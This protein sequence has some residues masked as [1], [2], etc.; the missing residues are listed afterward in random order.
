MPDSGLRLYV[1]AARTY[2][3]NIF[4]TGGLRL[5][6]SSLQMF[7][8]GNISADDCARELFKPS[9]D[10]ASL[11]VCNETKTFD[12]GFF[13]SDIISVVVSGLLCPPCLAIGPNH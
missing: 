10:L 1:L 7:L 11:R 4:A 6:S 13:V 5:R 8:H 3:I 2:Y 9:K 12:I